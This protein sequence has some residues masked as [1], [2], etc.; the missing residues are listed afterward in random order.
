MAFVRF[1]QVDGKTYYQLV[2]N[3]RIAGT[4]HQRVLMHLGSH[5]TVEAAMEAW[6][7]Q[8]VNL[9]EEAGQIRERRRGGS[10][11]VKELE[12]QA[13]VLEEKAERLRALSGD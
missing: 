5:A 6:A 2:K 9:R 1:K 3:E 13:D 11:R 8:V 12:A 4:H 7:T 10:V